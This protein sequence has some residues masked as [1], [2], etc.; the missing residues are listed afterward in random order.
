MEERGGGYTRSSRDTD[1]WTN[2]WD[3]RTGRHL[4]ELTVYTMGHTAGSTFMGSGLILEFWQFSPT[5]STACTAMAA[6]IRK[7]QSGKRTTASKA[8]SPQVEFKP[9]LISG[10][11]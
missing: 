11:V 3:V 5:E 2:I 7:Y 6:E 1:L 9:T 4:G 8:P 10:A